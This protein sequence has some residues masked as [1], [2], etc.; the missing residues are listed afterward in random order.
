MIEG[1]VADELTTY[2]SARMQHNN[3]STMEIS[4]WTP[5]G[6]GLKPPPLWLVSNGD[7]TAGPVSTNHLLEGARRG[8]PRHFR[9]KVIRTRTFK[10]AGAWRALD[11]LRE[12]RIIDETP[13]ER[14][15]RLTAR[16]GLFGLETLLRLSD[17]KSEILRLGLT[18]AAERLGADFGFVHAFEADS[19]MPVTRLSHGAGAE[20]RIGAPLLP[21]DVLAHVA[22]TRA[23]ALGDVDTHHAF[24]V[25]ASRLGA[26][27]GEVRGVAMVPIVSHGRTLAM[28]EL[29]RAGH[30]FRSSDGRSLSAVAAVVS[31]RLAQTR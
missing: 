17:E 14:A 28:I 8:L 19:Y 23:S 29:G 24:R 16:A 31:D 9:V 25:A 7:R 15:K 27:N 6:A 30:P 11:Q 20:T 22:R 26:R 3:S 13:L 18:V 1:P 10:S 5:P 2:L 12:V 21:N 4:T